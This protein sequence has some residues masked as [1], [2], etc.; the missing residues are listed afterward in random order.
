M[1]STVSIFESIPGPVWGVIG[2]VAGATLT[3]IT[4]LVANFGNN[5]RLSL[6]LAHDA[7]EKNIDRMNNLRREI[8]LSAVAEMTKASS[9]FG[10]LPHEDPSNQN[11]AAGLEGL[12]VAA[13]KLSLVA[14][15]GTQEAVD[16]LGT[17]YWK[18]T[19]KVIIALSPMQT[20]K[21]EMNLHGGMYDQAMIDVKRVI[22]AMN[23][24]RE[25]GCP[26]ENVML[27]LKD[28]FDFLSEQAADSSRKRHVATNEFYALC[29][30]YNHELMADM[31][32]L[33]VLQAKV[34]I[35]IRRDFGIETDEAR[36]M[37]HM[38]RQWETVSEAVDQANS[39]G[40]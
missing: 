18:L 39:Q 36:M 16:S 13:A 40:I 28:S 34:V 35:A 7:K 1:S 20:L 22:G 32:P 27:G 8:Y 9:Y 11:V 2:A 31:K 37:A 33:A 38:E 10:K 6:Q 3:S 25:G 4:N 12:Y 17:E 19:H 24:L 14:P 29:A 15:P 26:D 30:K 21:A 23:N 5:K